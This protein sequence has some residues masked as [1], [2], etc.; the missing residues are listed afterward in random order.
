LILAVVCALLGI[1]AVT[2]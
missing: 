1:A 2:K